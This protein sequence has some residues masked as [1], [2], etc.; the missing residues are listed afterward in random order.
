MA[1]M[2]QL[3]LAHVKPAMLAHMKRSTKE[4]TREAPATPR[5]RGRPPIRVER[6][7]ATALEII[8]EEGTE[9]L[10]MR[11]LAERLDSGTATLYRHFA[12]REELIASIVDRVFGEAHLST[13]EL[14][15]MSW[16]ESCRTIALAM[17]TSLS[18]HKNVTPLLPGH[19]PL[20]P[21][22]MAVR[23]ECIAVVLHSGFSKRLAARSW[24]TLAHY[25]LG[26]AIQLNAG[27]PR[28]QRDASKKAAVFHDLDASRFPATVAVADEFPVPLEDEFAFG[29]DLIISGL[30][31]LRRHD[32]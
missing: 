10:T 27:N 28:G 20:G 24:A 30:S 17:F 7:V 18:R 19:V 23:E 29:L 11:A 31:Q 3:L 6:I 21:N 22:A 4:V 1:T 8:D 14:R 16:Q 32:S 5:S 9:A 2:Y 13:E 25:V 15:S 12:N 26:F